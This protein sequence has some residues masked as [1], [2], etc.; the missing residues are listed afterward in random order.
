MAASQ[1]KTRT[2]NHSPLEW[3]GVQL[4]KREGFVA[5]SVSRKLNKVIDRLKIDLQTAHKKIRELEDQSRPEHLHIKKIF[6]STPEVPTGVHETASVSC[7][8]TFQSTSKA[9]KR[10][11]TTTTTSSKEK[12]AADNLTPPIISPTSIPPKALSF[13]R[14]WE[15]GPPKQTIHT[16]GPEAS[17]LP[18]QQATLSPP[19]SPYMAPPPPQPNLRITPE[20]SRREQAPHQ[21]STPALPALAPPGSLVPG[22]GNIRILS[23]EYIEAT[24]EQYNALDEFMA[25]QSS[26]T[27]TKKK[28]RR[29]KH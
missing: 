7:G 11:P 21:E 1:T 18:P 20:G 12:V 17:C 22:F 10:I 16:K 6:N 9:I 27:S 28:K 8:T 24:Q 19:Q 15:R 26:T 3:L 23:Q 13:W 25:L 4:S 5:R 14:K 29:K 2:K